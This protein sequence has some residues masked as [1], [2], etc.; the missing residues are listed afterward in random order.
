MGR[1]DDD[2]SALVVYGTP[3]ENSDELSAR[4]RAK[5]LDKGTLR[6][7]QPVWKQDARDSEGRRRFHGAF[8]GGF[9]AGYFNTVGS[10]DGWEP[11]TFKSSRGSR[12]DMRQHSAYDYMDDEERREMDSKQIGTAQEFD[13]FGFTA[14]EYARREATQETNRYASFLVIFPQDLRSRPAVIPGF[15]PDEIIVPPTDSIGVKLLRKMGWRHGRGIGPKHIAASSEVKREGRKAMLAL[16][17]AGSSSQDAGPSLEDSETAE[18]QLD[19]PPTSVPDFVRKIKD[20]VHGLG[21]DPFQSAPEFRHAKDYRLDDDKDKV[22]RRTLRPNAVTMSKGFGIGALEEMGD[23]DEDVYATGPHPEMMVLEDEEL[24]RLEKIERK[25]PRPRLPTVAVG[26]DALPGFKLASENTY[27]AEWFHP[28]VVPPDYVPVHKFVAALDLS[29][30]Q[31][32]NTP[33]E[34]PQPEDKT[35]VKLIDGMAILV[36]RSGT[37]LEA[38]SK[39]KNKE[40]PL[41]QFLFG[42]MG[43]DYYTRRLWE[44]RSKRGL[45]IQSNRDRPKLGASE[46]GQA[47]GEMPLQKSALPAIPAEDRARLQATLNNTFMKPSAE[48][49]KTNRLPFEDDPAKQARYEQFLKDKYTGGLR[50][51]NKGAQ[52]LTEAQ[53][54]QEILE[55]EA[56]AHAAR[57]TVSSSGANLLGKLAASSDRFTSG[58]VEQAGKFVKSIEE[59]QSPNQLSVPSTSYA[60]QPSTSLSYPRRTE[61]PWRPLPLL[62]KRFDVLDPY[63]GQSSLAKPKSRIESLTL[64]TPSESLFSSK[65]TE[66]I[67]SAAKVEEV[68]RESTPPV[69]EGEQQEPEEKIAEKPVDL[70]K[71]IF[72]DDEEEEA[73][74]QPVK[75]VDAANAALTRLVADDFLESL[76]KELGLAVPPPMPVPVKAP[77]DSSK[78]QTTQDTSGGQ[79]EDISKGQTTEDTSSGQP[80]DIPKGHIKFVKPSRKGEEPK[81]DIQKERDE[82]AQAK[83]AQYTSEPEDHATTKDD[84]DQRRSRDKRKDKSR[85]RREESSKE[86][87]KR[88]RRERKERHKRHK[89]KRRRTSSSTSSSSSSPSPSC[90]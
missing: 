36:A 62:C 30:S 50:K 4:K 29:Q 52:Q 41:F 40:N 76:G 70:Y 43:G 25:A 12:A 10:K 6:Q 46:R 39:E 23:E 3:L 13:T 84:K 16:A 45:Q 80:Q 47:L 5:A 44:E 48:P 56:V 68:Q 58:G 2:G 38:L 1:G 14:A 27:Q 34:A 67:G 18:E 21:F 8:T 89:S 22:K 85:D 83:D 59:Q 7:Q 33:L 66:A 9:S 63:T 28:P 65:I 78:G 60:P 19:L 51:M 31:S 90:S 20:N 15:V 17:S 35:L 88:K 77:E 26:K 24:E 87:S 54:A 32:D 71:A 69:D 86:R 42:G 55:F 82:K 81:A 57:G 53:R 75:N 37:Q 11:K 49:T 79:P 74:S 72:S 61:E 64:A 73:P